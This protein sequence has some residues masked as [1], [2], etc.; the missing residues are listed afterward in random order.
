MNRRMTTAEWGLLLLLS[1]LWGSSLFFLAIA[2]RELPPFTIVA[3]K[4]V[5]AA[6][7]LVLVAGLPCGR[8]QWGGFAVMALFNDAGPFVLMAVAAPY[9]TT[10]LASVL[11]ATNPL[12]TAVMAHWL[13]TDERMT[14]R[15]M[16]GVAIGFLGLAVMLGDGAMAMSL[17]ALLGAAAYLAA[18]VAYSYASIF[19]RRFAAERV[20]PMK[21]AA[22]QHCCSVL[23][24]VP[25]ALLVEHPWTLPLPSAPTLVALLA[26]GL[27]SGA[28][29]YTIFYRVLAT[30]GAT[31]VVLVTFLSPV[32]TILLGVAVLGERLSAQQASG[33][34]LIALG[35]LVL[36]GRVLMRV[37]AR[38]A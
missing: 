36:D 8:R 31:N 17:P 20:S 37:R 30:A 2:G 4:V 29:A 32:T 10:G 24:M 15:H 19:G 3:A 18:A 28:L 33:M 13:T 34:G 7:P 21:V 16:A 26:M 23:A 5:L 6:I 25:L 12:F 1:L 35:L 11:I 22:G 9:L 27:G 14:P 38:A